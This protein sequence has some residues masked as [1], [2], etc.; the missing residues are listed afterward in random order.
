MLSSCL[1]YFLRQYVH[2]T[3][4]I[5]HRKR[6]VTV[7]VTTSSLSLQPDLG[8]IRPIFVDLLVSNYTEYTVPSFHGSFSCYF[9]SVLLFISQTFTSMSFTQIAACLLQQRQSV[10]GLYL[11]YFKVP[12]DIGTKL[13]VSLDLFSLN[14]PH[15]NCMVTSYIHI[16]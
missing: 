10:I 15:I 9:L 12:P 2:G 7:C 16:H 5:A 3:P 11:A 1:K 8:I 14:M 4:I 6:F 13:L